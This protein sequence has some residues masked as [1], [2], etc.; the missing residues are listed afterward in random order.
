MNK[1]DLIAKMADKTGLKKV[2][3][4]KALKAFEETVTEALVA[5]DDVRLVGFGTFAVTKREAR[6]GVNPR[7]K[8]SIEI[9][10]S[11]APKF[12]AGKALKDA[13]NN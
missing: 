12:K 10:A 7:T 8:E 11:N 2:D 13:V 4:E 9:A 3:A 1:T 5:G 6:T